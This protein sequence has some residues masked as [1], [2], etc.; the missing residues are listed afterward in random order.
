MIRL[1]IIGTKAMLKNERLDGVSIA[2][3]DKAH[4][5]TALLAIKY[6]R[7]VM[8]EKPL[9]DNLRNARRMAV[10]ARARKLTILSMRQLHLTRMAGD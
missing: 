1:A 3:I 2:T 6:G 7:R 8:C 5:P 10:A 9:A 4:A